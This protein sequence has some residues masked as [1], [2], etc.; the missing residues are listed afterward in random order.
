MGDTEVTWWVDTGRWLRGQ[1][2][3]CRLHTTALGPPGPGFPNAPVVNLGLP[4]L[5]YDQPCGGYSSKF[6]SVLATSHSG[7]WETGPDFGPSLTT[8]PQ[9]VKAQPQSSEGGSPSTSLRVPPT[10]P[11][12]KAPPS[13]VHKPNPPSPHSRSGAEVRPPPLTA[14]TIKGVLFQMTGARQ[15]QKA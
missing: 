10:H 4:L 12:Q 1:G 11:T 15:P 6:T 9:Q 13:S 14:G 7:H 5:L 8:C 2:V 3:G